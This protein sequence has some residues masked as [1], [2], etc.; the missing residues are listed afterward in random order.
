MASVFPLL[1]QRREHSRI[2]DP[3]SCISPDPPLRH[4]SHSSYNAL[5]RK[6]FIIGCFLVVSL[7]HC[8]GEV[9]T[10][11]IHPNC[12]EI[13]ATTFEKVGLDAKAGALQF[14]NLVTVGE[15]SFKSDPRIISGISQSVR[16]DQVTGSL[17]CASRERGELKTLEQINHAWKVARF[18]RTNPTPAEAMEFDK[19]HPFPTT[20]P[21]I[22][23]PKSSL[24]EGVSADVVR[25]SLIQFIKQA[26]TIVRDLD[27]S[28]T[29]LSE[30]SKHAEQRWYVAVRGYLESTF[31]DPTFVHRFETITDMSA[32]MPPLSIHPFSTEY[33][34]IRGRVVNRQ[35]R[36]NQFLDKIP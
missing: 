5:M 4:S 17:I 21:T 6:Q 20:S 33:A 1:S 13:P 18:Y 30:E 7:T 32:L 16:D 29:T 27:K 22:Q 35:N 24:K 2:F 9:K 8:V 10:V 3:L 25:R 15:G 28:P 36:L 12:P 23:S 26:H 31:S 14:G 34:E 19:Q 11:K